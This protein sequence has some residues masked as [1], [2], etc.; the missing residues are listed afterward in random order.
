MEKGRAGSPRAGCL[1]LAELGVLLS[2]HVFHSIQDEQA[3]F[4]T[5]RVA[6]GCRQ[7]SGAGTGLGNQAELACLGDGLGAVGRAEE[8]ADVLFD[9]VEGEHEFPGDAR[10]R[11]F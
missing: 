4:R 5:V 8:V 10:V 11:S 3:N 1:P 2:R 6:C 9:R 7:G